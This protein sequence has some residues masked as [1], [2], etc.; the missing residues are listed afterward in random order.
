MYLMSAT[1]RQNDGTANMSEGTSWLCATVRTLRTSTSIQHALMLRLTVKLN[2]A[3]FP[4]PEASVPVSGK[5]T[6][7]FP[8]EQDCLTTMSSSKLRA[9]VLQVVADE[10]K[11]LGVDGEPQLCLVCGRT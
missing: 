9:A 5:N 11:A 4:F 6:A 7:Y 10:L 8:S 3:Y 2:S 1:T